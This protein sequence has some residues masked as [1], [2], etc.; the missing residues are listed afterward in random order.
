MQGG[1]NE[2]DGSI[3]ACLYSL[4]AQGE[5]PRWSCA[6]LRYFFRFPRSPL[7][8]RRPRSPSSI[9]LRSPPT[10]WSGSRPTHSALRATPPTAI[11]PKRVHTTPQFRAAQRRG[12]DASRPA[13]EVVPASYSSRDPNGLQLRPYSQPTGIFS[14]DSPNQ[15]SAPQTIS[16]ATKSRKQPT[17]PPQINPPQLQ[18]L[19][20]AQG[21]D[22]RVPLVRS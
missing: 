18:P 2:P 4:L 1:S 17:G 19:P 3:N 7:A 13:E 15:Q 20:T 5:W 14:G 9:E 8:M 10:A 12:G 21:T 11:R 16:A 22:S 6:L